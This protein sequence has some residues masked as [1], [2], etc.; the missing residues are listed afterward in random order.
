MALM[1][2]NY[3][4]KRGCEDL[5]NQ[6]QLRYECSVFKQSSSLAVKCDTCMYI[7]FF[8]PNDIFLFVC[9]FVS[10]GGMALVKELW[11][12]KLCPYERSMASVKEVWRSGLVEKAWLM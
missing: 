6:I 1:Q 7:S 11:T 10:E 4:H 8:T 12:V 9:L 3:T 2:F 5:Q